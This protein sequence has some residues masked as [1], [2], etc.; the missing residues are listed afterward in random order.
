MFSNL[1][2][3]PAK[4]QRRRPS[5]TIRAG[6]AKR[7]VSTVSALS[8]SMV[9]SLSFMEGL[10]GDE[11]PEAFGTGDG[12]AAK[13][14]K[15]IL[16]LPVEL[17]EIMCAHISKLDIKRLRLACKHLA[18]SVYLRID[19][20][21][22]SPNRANLD[23]LYSIL[24][25]PR[26]KYRVLEVVWDDARLQEYPTLD[27]FRE[28]ILLDERETKRAIE[29][30]LNEA[31]WIYSAG[32]P[33]YHALEHD[34]LF[35]K[36]GRLTEAA[37]EILLRYDDPFSSEVLAR[38][39]IMMDIE[40]SYALYQDLY[41]TEQAIMEQQ[42][43]VNA[44]HQ[45]L[46]GFPKLKRVTFT[47]EAWRPWTMQPRYNTPF[48]RALPV[49]FRKP[50]IRCESRPSSAAGQSPNHPLKMSVQRNRM[51][52]GF[53]GYSILVSALLNMPVPSIEEFIVE[54]E[55]EVTGKSQDA[56]D[57]TSA[58]YEDTRR[59]FQRTPLKHVKFF[60]NSEVDARTP[61]TFQNTSNVRS[62]LTEL[63]HL[64]HLDL[65]LNYNKTEPLFGHVPRLVPVP[66]ILT[67]QLKTL[68][69]RH[70]VAE[71]DDIFGLLTS[72][73]KLQHVTLHH[74]RQ[75]T[76]AP[77]WFLL[78]Q[79]L[80]AYYNTVAHVRKP[81]F[82]I[83][84]PRVFDTTYLQVVDE[85]VDAFLYRDG[86]NPFLRAS[87][88]TYAHLQPHLGWRVDTRHET[89]RQ[90]MRDVCVREEIQEWESEM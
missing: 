56:I 12:N 16:D 4:P 50:N 90:R 18:S 48:H 15:C 46:L 9:P 60:V 73:P 47:T 62:L 39:A 5:L 26:Y 36:N 85:E 20:V 23:Y 88:K 64:Q 57:I 77:C 8:A 19:R 2:I 29:S 53:R 76:D 22:V 45:A 89:V 81:R 51:P 37:K 72:L 14:R 61:S 49:G 68:T 65:S 63:R 79:R 34:D 52:V 38:N 3:R 55:N 84:Q 83:A 43:D 86:E 27:S 66:E 67:S 35:D 87:I 17:L 25:H 1:Q 6:V 80:R 74:L 21:Y 42:I 28:A 41:K 24:A 70:V 10:F 33:E 75:W 7:R 54:L 58:D 78:F 11:F 59:M 31:I 69:L 13:S 32:N 30:R 82:T 40:E 71:K 44:L